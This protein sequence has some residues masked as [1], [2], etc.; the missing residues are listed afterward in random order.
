MSNIYLAYLPQTTHMHEKQTRLTH[1][2]QEFATFQL[3][4]IQILHT[5]MLQGATT[6]A[7]QLLYTVIMQ[8][9]KKQSFQFSL[10]ASQTISRLKSL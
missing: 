5:V 4:H 7:L 3:L 2:T 6:W 10:G 8:G 9:A 1:N